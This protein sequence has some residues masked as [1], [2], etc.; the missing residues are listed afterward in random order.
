MSG[1]GGE[2]VRRS[3]GVI[4]DREMGLS[5]GRSANS[6]RGKYVDN[7]FWYDLA[8]NLQNKLEPTGPIACNTYFQGA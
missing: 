1:F 2:Q 6:L 4:A 8:G 5:V 7:Q 3:K